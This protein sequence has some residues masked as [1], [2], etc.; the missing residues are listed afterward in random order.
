MNDLD[1]HILDFESTKIFTQPE[2]V[3]I[4]LIPW[5]LPLEKRLQLRVLGVFE[6][7]KMLEVLGI[8]SGESGVEVE[9]EKDLRPAF[10]LR[11]IDLHIEQPTL[12]EALK[13][14]CKDLGLGFRM[15]KEHSKVWVCK[16]NAPA[17][18]AIKKE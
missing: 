10:A 7:K 4:H 17:T 11:T 5:L 13:A 14:V 8:W 15:D 12:E 16:S 3:G 9:L 6:G 1:K 2:D 18:E